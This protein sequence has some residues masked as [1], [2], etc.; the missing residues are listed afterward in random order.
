MSYSRRHGIAVRYASSA[1]EPCYRGVLTGRGGAD[2]DMKELATAEHR[3]VRV[4]PAAMVGKRPDDVEQAAGQQQHPGCDPCVNPHPR[5]REAADT[6]E[7]D[8]QRA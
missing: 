2:V 8:E 5:Q 7:P 1:G 6:A 3:R 4:G